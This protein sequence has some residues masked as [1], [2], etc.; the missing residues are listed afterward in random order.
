MKKLLATLIFASLAGTG[1]FA[2]TL[3]FLATPQSV[4]AANISYPAPVPLTEARLRLALEMSVF[5]GPVPAFHWVTP[6]GVRMKY[7]NRVITQHG[8]PAVA[9][10]YM[11]FLRELKAELAREQQTQA[12][13]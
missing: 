7:W 1:I 3:D 9:D 2:A 5:G 4:W 11:T 13:N 12:E 10:Q 8:L 6:M